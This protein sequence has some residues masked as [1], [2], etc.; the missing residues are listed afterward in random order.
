MSFIGSDT[1]DATAVRAVT[2]GPPTA[3]S[4]QDFTQSRTKSGSTY[5]YTIYRALKPSDPNYYEI[6]LGTKFPI[7]YAEKTDGSDF[8]IHDNTGGLDIIIS[9]NGIKPEINLHNVHMF[10]MHGIAM[11]F[12]WVNFGL[13]MAGTNRWY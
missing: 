12:A 9:A 1:G 8:S 6:K 7:I 3:E 10:A 2:Y 11:W 13:I 4:A 5:N